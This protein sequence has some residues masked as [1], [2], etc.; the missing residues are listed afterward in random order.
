MRI[1]IPLFV[2][3]L[4]AAA[5]CDLMK[6]SQIE[7]KVV[8]ALAKDPRT[9]AYEFEVSYEAGTVS[10][11]GEVYKPEEMDAVAEIAKAVPGVS[12]VVN[13]CHVEEQGSNG[14]IQDDT[15]PML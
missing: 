5:S 10:I 6:G 7:N 13:N 9:S 15:V 2:L 11:T 1:I 3:L 14:M 8:A 12:S 4:L